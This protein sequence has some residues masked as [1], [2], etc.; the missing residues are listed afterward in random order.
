MKKLITLQEWYDIQKEEYLEYLEETASQGKEKQRIQLD[1][2]RF[3]QSLLKARPNI[4]DRINIR[5]INQKYDTSD[6]G[7][8][9]NKTNLKIAHLGKRR[10]YVNEGFWSWFDKKMEQRNKRISKEK[11]LQLPLT[12]AK[13]KTLGIDVKKLDNPKFKWHGGSGLES[14]FNNDNAI[15][16]LNQMGTKFNVEI[17]ILQPFWGLFSNRFL[18]S[19]EVNYILNLVITQNNMKLLYNKLSKIPNSKTSLNKRDYI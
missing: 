1:T 15:I 10:R 12:I 16:F 19:N 5:S 6:F 11:K 14:M 7:N 8:T 4:K 13:F 3:K 2:K 9:D 17:N 18:T